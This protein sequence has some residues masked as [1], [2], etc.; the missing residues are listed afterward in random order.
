MPNLYNSQQHPF[1]SH[2]SF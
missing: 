2:W 1:L